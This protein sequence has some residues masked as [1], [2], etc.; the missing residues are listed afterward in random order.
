MVRMRAVGGCLALVEQMEEFVF[1]ELELL[2]VDAQ[3]AFIQIVSRV[4][5]PE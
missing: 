2:E 5:F 3:A 4:R 1:R